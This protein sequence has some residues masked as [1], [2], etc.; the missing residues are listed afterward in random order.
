MMQ[1]TLNTP[2]LLFPAISLLMIAYTNRFLALASLIR[3]LKTTYDQSH[4]AKLIVQI[5][6]LRRRIIIIRNMQ[7]C[8][9]ASILCC[10]LCMFLL[11][12]GFGVAGVVVFQ[13]GLV[14][15]IASLWLCFIEIMLSGSALSV[16]LK[17]LEK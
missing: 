14:L 10:V 15:M 16:E 12:A 4:D 7:L 11:F 17:D 13:V 1:L 3:H 9:I 5:A 8:G 6:T 2:A